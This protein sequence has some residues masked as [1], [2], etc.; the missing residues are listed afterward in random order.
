MV[1]NDYFTLRVAPI[2]DVV[3]FLRARHILAE[4]WPSG[5]VSGLQIG[6]DALAVITTWVDQSQAGLNFFAM[7]RDKK[8]H[9][10][11]S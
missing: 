2:Q 4:G 6:V 11:T 3:S 8:L 9:P 1:A 5:Q 10:I 7:V